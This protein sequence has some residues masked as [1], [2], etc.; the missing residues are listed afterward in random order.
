MYVG[1]AG[2]PN[3][4]DFPRPIPGISVAGP[5]HTGQSKRTMPREIYED[6]TPRGQ[7]ICAKIVALDDGDE[8]GRASRANHPVPVLVC[9]A[10]NGPCAVP[11]CWCAVRDS[12]GVAGWRAEWRAPTH[13]LVNTGENDGGSVRSLLSPAQL[14][15]MRTRV[16]GSQTGHWPVPTALLRQNP[17]SRL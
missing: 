1:G 5:G 12:Y 6:L 11:V 4:S 9:R 8:M 10:R 2:T 13:G 14:Q 15:E 16:G 7:E 17:R 3:L